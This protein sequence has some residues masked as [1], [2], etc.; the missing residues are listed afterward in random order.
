MAKKPSPQVTNPEEIEAMDM[1]DQLRILIRMR[2][3]LQG[4]ELVCPREQSSMTPCIA[5]DGHTAVCFGAF[6]QGLCVGCWSSV[7]ALLDSESAKQ[8]V[9]I[10]ASPDFKPEPVTSDSLNASI[11]RVGDI[12]MNLKRRHARLLLALKRITEIGSTF[13]KYPAGEMVTIANAALAADEEA[14]S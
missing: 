4:S 8:Q 5:R 1:A 10:P 7:K 9:L 13:D 3:G 14:G 11:D 2:T 6:G 12:A